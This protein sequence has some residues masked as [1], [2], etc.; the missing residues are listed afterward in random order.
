MKGHGRRKVIVVE[1]LTGY[2]AFSI[3]W[4]NLNNLRQDE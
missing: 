2:P 4:I 1:Y 3:S